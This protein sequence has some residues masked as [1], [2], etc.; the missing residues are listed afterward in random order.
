VSGPKVA[1]IT[2]QFSRAA[3]PENGPAALGLKET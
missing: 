2:Y 3:E 1:Y